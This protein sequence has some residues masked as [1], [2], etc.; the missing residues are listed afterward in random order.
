MKNWFYGFFMCQSMFC[1]IPC[2]CRVWDEKARDTMLLCLPLVGLEIGLLWWALAWLCGWLNLAPLLRG[3][4]L[5]AYPFLV[6]GYI[7]LDGF[8]D[9]TDAVRSYRSL[10]RRREILKDSHVGSFSVISCCLVLLAQFA[11]FAS[12]KTGA[13]LRI[14]ILL[15]V[16]SRCG[17]V[18]AILR[19]EPMS[20]SQYVH[21]ERSVKKIIL[22][23]LVLAAALDCGFLF[24]GKYALALLG[25][26]AGYGLALRKSYRSLEGV[27]GDVTG[28]ALTLSELAGAAVLALL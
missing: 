1:A 24:F 5:S 23:A 11:L 19:L 7:H 27:N 21:R 9:V 14:L 22:P 25:C 20:T 18:L 6:T 15:P 8:M 17:S 13:D 28:Y 4:V 16:V 3:L 12:V 10:E 2:P 26:V